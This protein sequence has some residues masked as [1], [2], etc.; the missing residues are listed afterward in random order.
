MTGGP[1]E[2]DRLSARDVRD[3]RIDPAGTP[4]WATVGVKADWAGNGPWQVTIAADNLLD[5]AYRV[6]GSGLDA[7]GRNFS[8]VFRTSW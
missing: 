5:K 6:H 4:G 8:V 2:Q 1:G 3:V 7:P